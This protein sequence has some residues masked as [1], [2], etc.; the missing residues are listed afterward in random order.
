MEASWLNLRG[1]PSLSGRWD[2]QPGLSRTPA[3]VWGPR[4]PAPSLGLC[5]QQGLSEC[6]QGAFEL[7]ACPWEGGGVRG[8]PMCLAFSIKYLLCA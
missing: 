5:T 7:A 2:F 8:T 3:L 1:A 6:Q 4:L